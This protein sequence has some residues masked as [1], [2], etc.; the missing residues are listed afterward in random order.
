MSEIKDKKKLVEDL[1]NTFKDRD[2]LHESYKGT[3]KEI[4]AY[5]FSEFATF[6]NENPMSTGQ[7]VEK[8]INDFVEE[9]FKPIE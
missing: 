6:A 8:W 4:I 3:M 7:E 2:H 9:K 1:I 5:A